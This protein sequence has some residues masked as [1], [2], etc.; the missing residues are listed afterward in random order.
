MIALIPNLLPLM[1][2]IF[3]QHGKIFRPSELGVLLR[4]FHDSSPVMWKTPLSGAKA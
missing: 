3:N 2:S 4:A 1:L